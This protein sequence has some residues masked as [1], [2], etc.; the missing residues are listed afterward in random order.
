MSARRIQH[1]SYVCGDVNETN[2]LVFGVPVGEEV[3]VSDTDEA[4]KIFQRFKERD[5]FS[6][7]IL[8][9]VS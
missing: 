6:Y 2:D 7:V 4:R 3:I 1:F 5:R 9:V 8:V